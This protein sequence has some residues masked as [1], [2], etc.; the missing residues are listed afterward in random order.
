MLARKFDVCNPESALS[1]SRNAQLLLG[2]GLI[3]IPAQSND[4]SCSDDTLCNIGGLCEYMEN[5]FVKISKSSRDRQQRYVD[6]NVEDPATMSELDVLAKVAKHQRSSV[7][8]RLLMHGQ[9]S[10]DHDI[11]DIDDEDDD[12]MEVD[13]QAMLVEWNK[14]SVEPFGWRSWLWQTCTEVGFYQTCLEHTDC[15]FATNYHTV[16]MDLEICNSVFG[17][18]PSQVYENVQATLD[19]YGGLNIQETSRVLSVNGNV[20][21]WSV[22]ALQTSPKYSLPTAWADGQSHHFWTHPV[23]DTDEPEIVEVRNYIY[24]VV[25]DW[26]GLSIDEATSA[27]TLN[28]LPKNHA[29][30]MDSVDD[31]KL[32]TLR[33]RK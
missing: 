11:N 17:F 9:D 14:T 20:D 8:R 31:P 16:D 29:K 22:L 2:D 4:P 27:S 23:K 19:H 15:P 18:T 30:E 33:G 12:C 13:F 5:E 1:E 32:S 7:R 28:K 21:P 26:L 24:S 6:G 10:D 25:L 3:N